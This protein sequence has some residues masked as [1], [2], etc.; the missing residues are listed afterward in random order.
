VTERQMEDLIA[1]FPNELIPGNN[2]VLKGHQQSFAAVGRFDLFFVDGFQTN[3]LM[4]LKARP[5]K[6]EDATQL[7]KYKEELQRRGERNILMWLVAPL[8]PRPVRDFLDH[9]G[10]QYS[11]IHEVEF[12]MVA[13]RHDIGLATQS[14]N[15]AAEAAEAASGELQK[16]RAESPVVAA[17]SADKTTHS[18]SSTASTDLVDECVALLKQIDATITRQEWSQRR[19][20]IKVNGR[21]FVVIRAETLEPRVK[22][23]AFLAGRDEWRN[24]L[25][26]AGLEVYVASKKKKTEAQEKKEGRLVRFWLRKE[27]LDHNRELIRSL[28]RQSL[29]ECRVAISS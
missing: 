19:T 15:S 26:G 29:Q 24:R 23:R 28:F 13:E 7:A 17:E 14:G 18:R 9:I 16:T 2:L 11:E 12:R 6:Y 25:R 8:I 22:I 1:Q 21:E 5:A 4:E 27:Q 10:I 20:A 3:V